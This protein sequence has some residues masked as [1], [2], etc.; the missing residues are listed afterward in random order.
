MKKYYLTHKYK[1]YYSAICLI[2]TLPLIGLALYFFQNIL[3]CLVPFL[4]AMA[5]V[6]IRAVYWIQSESLIVSE[7]GVDYDTPGSIYKIKWQDFEKIT[8]CWR[9]AIRQEGLAVD[10]S[11]FRIEGG[12]L[13]GNSP[14]HALYDYPQKVCIPLNCF[15]VNWRDSELGQQIKQNAPHLFEKE[16]S[17]QSA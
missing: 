8:R 12:S 17:V 11:K 13:V 16:K 5:L 15:A 6:I 10:Q 7:N 9:F 3:L 1:F 14:S 4:I 2:S